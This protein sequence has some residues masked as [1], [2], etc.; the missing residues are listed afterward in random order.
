[1]DFFERQASAQRKTKLLIF[2]F[3]MAVIGIIAVLQIVFAMILKVSFLD[4]QLLAMVAGGVVI[5]VAGGSIFKIMELSQGGRV[6]ATMLGGELLQP[7]TQDLNEKKLLNI[8]EEMAI[9]SGVPVPEVYLLPDETINAFAAGHGPGDT[10]IGVTRGCIEQL[11][12]DQLQGVIA[13]EFSHILHGDMKLNLTLIGVLNGIL[14]LAFLGGLLMRSSLFIRPDSR[15]DRDNKSGGLVLAII[16]AGVALYLV[17]WIGVFFGNLIKAAVS[18]QREFLADASA[19]QFTRNPTGIAGALWKIG[20]FKSELSS[21]RAQEASHMFFGNGVPNQWVSLFATH[22]PLDERIKAIAP[23]FELSSAESK[24]TPPPLP[25]VKEKESTAAGL[26]RLLPVAAA[27][28]SDIPDFAGAAVRQAHSACAF[29][30]AML[31]D[32]DEGL[33]A[34]QL[35]GLRVDEAMMKEVLALFAKRSQIAIPQ[36]LPLVDLAIPT[37]R[38]LSPDQ[39]AVF[40]KNVRHLIESDQQVHLFEFALQKT[41]IRH[42]D[43]YF[44]KSTGAAVKFRFIGPLMPDIGVLL[45]AMAYVGHT[46]EGERDAAFAAGLKELPIDA[47]TAPRRDN[48]CDLNRI[49]AALDQVAQAAPPIKKVIIAAC[50][51]VAL[52]DNLL[53]NQQYELLRAIA[54]SLDC[55]LPPLPPVQT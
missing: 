22:P 24:I 43:L 42:L 25:E 28:L 27:L 4:L 2:Y 34:P 30:Y 41:V 29:V 12:R 45:S 38:H 16:A 52:Q 33:R 3:A 13:H 6:V 36:R 23:G 46:D 48:T 8:V 1:M 9:A 40:R 31:L 35:Q 54:D 37:L 7:S 26:E 19:V 15:S 14:G 49:D 10:A 21:P 55:P 20:Q 5:V 17:G 32:E 47:A 53:D 18:R 11:N 51:Q 44:T 39:Y 50:R